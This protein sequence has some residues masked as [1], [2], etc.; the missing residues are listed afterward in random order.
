M[1]VFFFF[2]IWSHKYSAGYQ[3]DAAG[4]FSSNLFLYQG[5]IIFIYSVQQD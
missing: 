3:I 5:Q 1:S 4:S 2:D